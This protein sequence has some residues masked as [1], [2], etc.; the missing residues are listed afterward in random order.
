MAIRNAKA[1]WEGNLEGGNGTIALGSGALET[2]YSFQSR[3][4]EQGPG[5]NPEELIAGAHAGCFSMALSANLTEAGYAPVRIETAAKVH[6]SKT[7][8][9]FVIPK[10]ELETEAEVPGVDNDT[11]EKLA[12]DA[13]A[14]CPVSKVLGAAEITLSSKLLSQQKA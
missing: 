13:K 4:T 1:V 5:T 6:L 14:N 7:Q 2:P 8:D 11:F 3:F 10:I 9:G 12:A